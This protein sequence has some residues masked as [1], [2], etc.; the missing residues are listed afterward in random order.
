M[1]KIRPKKD[2][3]P[4]YLWHLSSSPLLGKDRV[5]MIPKKR[6]VNRGDTEPKVPRTCVSIYPSGGFVAIPLYEKRR[7]YLYRSEEKI[8]SHYTYD[9]LDAVAT[10]ERWILDYQPF[11]KV[12][13]FSAQEFNSYR[14]AVNKKQIILGHNG[15]CNTARIREAKELIQRRLRRKFGI[16]RKSG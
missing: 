9:V 7:Y 10:G 3:T 16:T 11:I 8:T 5:V 1:K 2:S 4:R 14:E 13:E 15:S 6:G 12:A